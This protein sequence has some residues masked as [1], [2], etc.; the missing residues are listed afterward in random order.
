MIGPGK[1][2]SVLLCLFFLFYFPRVHGDELWPAG[3]MYV[4]VG[5]SEPTPL[6]TALEADASQMKLSLAPG[7]GDRK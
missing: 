4:P 2:C 7:V 6:T 1:C 3:R 5:T